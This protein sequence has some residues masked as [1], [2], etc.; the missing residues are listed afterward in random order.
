[1]CTNRILLH[2]G[3]TSAGPLIPGGSFYGI[4]SVLAAHGTN[5]DWSDRKNQPFGRHC[6]MVHIDPRSLSPSLRLQHPPPNPRIVSTHWRSSTCRRL[7]LLQPNLLSRRLYRRLL[8]FLLDR[9]LRRRSI[10]PVQSLLVL[11]RS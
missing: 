4:V 1:M 6:S 3:T 2:L 11:L 7:R 8:P 10:Q 5:L 9:H